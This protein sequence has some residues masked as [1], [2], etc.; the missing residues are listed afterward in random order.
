LNLACVDIY[1]IPI[2]AAQNFTFSVTSAAFIPQIAFIGSPCSSNANCIDQQTIA[3]AGTATSGTIT[4]NAAGTYFILVGDS[5]ADNPGCG[6]YNLT[7][8][9]TLPVKL[10]DF[11]IQ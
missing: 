2:G 8:N 6:A 1:S 11:S 7:V 4:G 5:A 3:A 10:Q 9:P